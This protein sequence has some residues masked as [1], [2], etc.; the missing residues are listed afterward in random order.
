MGSLS[1]SKFD[2]F[3]S[4]CSSQL[5]AGSCLCPRYSKRLGLPLQFHMLFNKIG[6]R[7]QILLGS[8]M[9]TSPCATDAWG[10]GEEKQK[11]KLDS[12]RWA[13][14]VQQALA[15]QR[16]APHGYSLIFL[17]WKSH[18][19]QSLQRRRD[20]FF[21]TD[22]KHILVLPPSNKTPLRS[23]E[24]KRLERGPGLQ[25]QL[26]FWLAV[27]HYLGQFS[28]LCLCFSSPSDGM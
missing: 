5:C 25:S 8:P 16:Q 28:F 6:A 19:L 14:P 18:I 11:T 1:L 13:A 27:W 15:S 22:C 17:L 2:V 24:P 21:H 3:S 4:N 7:A 20:L 23:I 10:R 9:L 12:Q 26:C